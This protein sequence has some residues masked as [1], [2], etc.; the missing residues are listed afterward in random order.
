MRAIVSEAV[1]SRI[2]QATAKSQ[3]IRVDLPDTALLVN[4]DSTRLQQIVVNLINNAIKYTPSDGRIFVELHAESQSVELRVRDTGVGLAPDQL[5]RIFEPFVQLTRSHNHSSEG[6]GIGLA[7]VQRLVELHGG[8][9]SVSS[10]GL[11][12]GSEFRVKLPREHP[13]PREPASQGPTVGTA[14]NGSSPSI[15]RRI[16]LIEDNRD[17]RRMLCTLLGMNGHE[18]AESTDGLSGVDAI[19]RLLP[20]MALIDLGLPGIDGY[21]VA[22]RVRSDSD[23]RH[24]RLI[25]MSGYG[26]PEDRRRSLS[27]GFDA[28]LVKPVSSEQLL[29]LLVNDDQKA[30]CGA[31]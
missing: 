20:D 1:G 14:T 21:E 4:G 30:E 6:L 25:A 16:V 19:R 7:L 8:S 9:V 15:R 12:Q 5:S 27:A 26:Q 23:C 11:G 13:S 2:E 10:A 22:K 28:H 29:H 18:V 31:S 3:Q 17:V 24:V